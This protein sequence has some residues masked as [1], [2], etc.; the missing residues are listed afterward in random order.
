MGKLNTTLSGLRRWK[1][2]GNI[3]PSSVLA[4]GSV[5]LMLK[6]KFLWQN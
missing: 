2:E 4:P 3:R 5:Y 6:Y 1:V